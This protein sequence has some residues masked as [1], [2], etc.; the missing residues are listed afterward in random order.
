MR[1]IAYPC[2]FG[3]PFVL[4]T[5]ARAERA[6]EKHGRRMEG[7]AVRLDTGGNG[8][9][10]LGALDHDD[11]HVCASFPYLCAHQVSVSYE[12]TMKPRWRFRGF[13]EVLEQPLLLERIAD[14]AR[15]IARLWSRPWSLRRL[16]SRLQSTEVLLELQ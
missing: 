11:T 14:N 4:L 15:V 13:V 6:A 2:I 7:G 16:S 1:G 3:E 5:A 12:G 9:P 10:R 8:S